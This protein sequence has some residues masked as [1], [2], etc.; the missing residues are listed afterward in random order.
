MFQ[1]N[2]M[3]EAL[4]ASVTNRTEVH[5]EDRKPA[6][7]LGFELTLPNTILDS[8]DPTLRE[9]L[10]KAK[11]DAEPELPGMVPSTPI[12]RCNSIDRVTLPTNYTGWTLAV[13]D[14]IDDT[15]PMVFGGAK[16]DKFVVE[17]K[18]GG[19]VVLRLRVGTSDIDAEKAGKLA[20]HN[21]QS[22]WVTITKPEA[23]PDAIDGS[24][25]AFEADHPGASA[26]P[27]FDDEAADA[28]TEAFLS[29]QTSDG[30]PGEDHEDEPEQ[31]DGDEVA[32][33]DFAPPPAAEPPKGPRGAP[34]KYRN[35][36]TGETW[37]GRG[38]K[39]R[40]LTRALESGRLLHEFAVQESEGVAASRARMA[41]QMPPCSASTPCRP[42]RCTRRPTAIS[43][44]SGRLPTA[45][46]IDPA[47]RMPSA[48]ADTA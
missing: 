46:A 22:V 9:A 25:A 2:E 30:Y 4:L 3:T 28:A 1:L 44:C 32:E 6:V 40:W 24:S 17:A 29:V 39:P 10:Y 8:I 7:S 45:T 23:Q 16:V 19:S 12:L 18:Q 21:G 31:L 20:M 37:S 47:S 34:A 36:E 5:G 33:D 43:A 48:A 42:I 11:P 13:D 26:G 27:L 38:L 35:A 41:A 15:K 14:G